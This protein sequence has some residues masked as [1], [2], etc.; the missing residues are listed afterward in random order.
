MELK[1][2]ID[3]ICEKLREGVLQRSGSFQFHCDEAACSFEIASD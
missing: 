1:D 2:H 3:D